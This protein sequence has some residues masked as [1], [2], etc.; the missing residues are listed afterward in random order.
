MET[1][2][3]SRDEAWHEARRIACT[4]IA[5]ILAKVN[6]CRRGKPSILE[7]NL[8]EAVQL[9]AESKVAIAQQ[10]KEEPHP[11]KNADAPEIDW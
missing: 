4:N 11:V 5:Q 10:N 8:A 1:N 7:L 3:P 6:A 9:L 2:E